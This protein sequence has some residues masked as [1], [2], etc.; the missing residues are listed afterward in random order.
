M[1][2][3]QMSNHSTDSQNIPSLNFFDFNEIKEICS[4]M[5]PKLDKK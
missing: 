3:A 5:N 2:N 4:K 1:V